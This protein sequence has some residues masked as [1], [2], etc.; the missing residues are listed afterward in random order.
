MHAAFGIAL[1]PYALPVTSVLG[2]DALRLPVQALPGMQAASSRETSGS[3]GTPRSR[4]P[5][6]ASRATWNNSMYDPTY[7]LNPKP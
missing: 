6:L 7:S 5:S 4:A 3:T 2:T 1:N